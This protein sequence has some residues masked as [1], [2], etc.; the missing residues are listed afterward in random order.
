M[1]YQ[2]GIRFLFMTLLKS[3]GFLSSP[4][5]VQRTRF[6]LTSELRSEVLIRANYIK[7]ILTALGDRPS[8][9]V[10]LF[11]NGQKLN[12]DFTPP[13]GAMLQLSAAYSQGSIKNAFRKSIVVGHFRCS[14]CRISV[15]ITFV[16]RLFFLLSTLAS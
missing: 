14:L 12:D 13:R 7:N 3:G 10:I 6:L 4:G 1:E 5:Q 8:I 16:C 9:P 2:F 11:Q 15:F